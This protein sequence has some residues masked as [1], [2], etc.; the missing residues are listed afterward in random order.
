L[1]GSEV[2][3][4][5]VVK[6]ASFPTLVTRRFGAGKVLYSAID[7]SWR[8]RYKVSDQYHQRFWNQVARWVMRAPL[9]VSDDHVGL[10]SGDTVYSIG[11]VATIR[12]RLQDAQG[13]GISDAAVEALIWKEGQLAA[14]VFLTPD[15]QNPGFYLGQTA[16]L[17]TGAYEVSIRASGFPQ[18]SM[19]ARTQFT[20]TPESYAE[21]QRL[22]CNRE[23]LE[24]MSTESKG[25]FLLEEDIQ[26]LTG[27]LE[28]LSNG[29]V[30]ESDTLLW[31]SFWWFA[32]IVGLLAVEWWLRKRGGLM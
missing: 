3:A 31:Q 5:T 29:R 13:R 8:W 17:T 26:Q 19:K 28:P 12:S 6:D 1:P 24:Q 10:D 21:L 22:A 14:S 15:P 16:P 27:L 20:V 18:E 23:L 2:L 30:V 9:A 32:A 7:E 11:D 25:K 4:E